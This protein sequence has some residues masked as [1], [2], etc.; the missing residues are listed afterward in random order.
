M[1]A[2]EPGCVTCSRNLLLFSRSSS[3][4]GSSRIES[5]TTALSENLLTVEPLQTL[6]LALCSFYIFIF[7]YLQRAEDAGV[8]HAFVRSQ[9]SE[10]S[11]EDVEMPQN[12]GDETGEDDQWRGAELRHDLLTAPQNARQKYGKRFC[13]FPFFSAVPPRCTNILGGN[14]AHM[15]LILQE[16]F[17]K[18]S[19]WK[20]HTPFGLMVHWSQL[21]LITV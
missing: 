15:M 6:Y 19:F 7:F 13:R 18:Q 4:A 17:S 1:S 12:L 11:A 5:S 3:L 16:Q 20:Q 2:A 9:L 10:A 8:L 14:F 21:W